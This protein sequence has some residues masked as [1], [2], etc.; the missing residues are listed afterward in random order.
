M[1]TRKV[2]FENKS[3]VFGMFLLMLFLIVMVLVAMFNYFILGSS[4][5]TTLHPI[6][7]FVDMIYGEVIMF[8]SPSA[9]EWFKNIN[10]KPSKDVVSSQEISKTSSN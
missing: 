3:F 2:N 1:L 9:G 7:K 8:F 10:K 4:N 6:A 5:N